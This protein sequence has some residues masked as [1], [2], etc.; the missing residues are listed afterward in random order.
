MKP[1]TAE[2]VAKAEGDWTTAH[3]EMEAA[4]SPNFDAACFHAHQCVEKY[5]KARLAEEGKSLPKTHDLSALLDLLLP[6]EPKWIRFRQELDV[7]TDLGIEVRYPGVFAE[8]ED[9]RRA[10][11]TAGEVR[12]AARR[13]LGEVP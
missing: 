8:I 13:S 6:L 4:G 9:A 10:V 1:V 7:L 3:R 11:E 5:L 12:Q 2:W